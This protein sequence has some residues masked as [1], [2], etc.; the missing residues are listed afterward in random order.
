MEG[1]D[2]PRLTTSLGVIEYLE[3]YGKICGVLVMTRIR[4]A[5]EEP[6]EWCFI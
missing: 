6:R 4:Y 5:K 3:G 2:F 1:V